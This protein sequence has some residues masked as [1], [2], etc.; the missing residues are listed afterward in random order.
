MLIIGWIWTWLAVRDR[1]GGDAA[2]VEG[3]HIDL[4]AELHFVRQAAWAE[5][6]DGVGSGRR[7]VGMGESGHR[8]HP[9]VW[10]SQQL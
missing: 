3:I 7:I 2:R 5:G 6:F 4:D 1:G 9:G 10:R 8:E